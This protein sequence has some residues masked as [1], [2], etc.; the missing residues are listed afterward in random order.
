MILTKG[1]RLMLLASLL[2]SLMN[3]CVKML[4]HMPAMQIVFF[5]SL[6]SLVMTLW[7]LKRLHLP[8]WGRYRRVLLLRGMFG[9]VSLILFFILLQR[10]PLASAATLHFTAPFFTTIMAA[11]F[12]A[13]PLS[14]KQLVLLLICFV[15]VLLMKSFDWR[16]GWIDVGIGLLSAFSAGAAYSCI[17]YLKDKEHPLV[18]MLYFPLITVPV[19]GVWSWQYAYMPNGIDWFWLLAIGLLTQWA[20]LLMTKAYQAEPAARVAL[21]SYMGL[22][23]AL[24]F[25]YILFGEVF[26][27]Q[28]LLGML[29]VLLGVLL[30]AKKTTLTAR[31]VGMKKSA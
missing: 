20:Q 5:R 29:M 17:R 8:I 12:L 28:S 9:A 18:I 26:S 24:V 21:T 22:V 25:G 30:N 3:V 10:I 31:R 13:E 11:V 19:T 6:M 1:V 15:G 23:Y 16:I 4:S 2:F 7:A 27:W 14:P